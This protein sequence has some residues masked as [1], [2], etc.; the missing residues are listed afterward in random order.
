MS[1]YK[2]RKDCLCPRYCSTTCCCPISGPQGPPGPPGKFSPAYGSFWQN[3]FISIP[4]NQPIPFNNMGPSAGGVI[5]S[6]P[7]TIFIPQAG[8]YEI[9]YVVTA[10][11]ST[12]PT[13]SV[14]GV[15]VFL[16]AIPVPKFQASFG[17]ST[18]DPDVS[19]CRQI[20]GTA[21]I[22][23]PNNSTLQLKNIGFDLSLCNDIV[24]GAALTIKK[25]N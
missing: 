23:V 15:N 4:F 21:I 19:D 1:S 2:K 16:N 12:T 24:S 13:P 9:N 25:L 7:T 14:H 8:D 18:F 3:Q 20:T 11:I 6:N 17:I 22:S 10:I 5:L